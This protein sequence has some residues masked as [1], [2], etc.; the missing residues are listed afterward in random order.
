MSLDFDIRFDLKSISSRARR[1]CCSQPGASL[2]IDF[3]SLKGGMSRHK[4]GLNIDF[5]CFFWCI[6]Q[7][8]LEIEFKS[9]TPASMLLAAATYC[10]TLAKLL[11]GLLCTDYGPLLQGFLFHRAY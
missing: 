5:T 3:K 10:L 4:Q 7:G 6:L 11:S 8:Q 2:E 1:G 9:S